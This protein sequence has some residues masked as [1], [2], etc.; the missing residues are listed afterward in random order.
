[1]KKLLLIIACSIGLAANTHAASVGTMKI[2]TGDHGGVITVQK[3]VSNRGEED[4]RFSNGLVTLSDVRRALV[5]TTDEEN[6]QP[7][8]DE[9]SPEIADEATDTNGVHRI[10]VSGRARFQGEH[11]ADTGRKLTVNGFFRDLHP[12][13]HTLKLVDIMAQGVDGELVLSGTVIVNGQEYEI[14]SAPEATQ[15]FV[16]RLIWLIRST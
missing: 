2:F 9:A 6:D 14:N 15:R 8:V 1:M 12:Q 7:A 13:S 5:R 16:R 11:T 10:R 3:R 4:S